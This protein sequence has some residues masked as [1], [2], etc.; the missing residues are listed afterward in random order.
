MLIQHNFITKEVYRPVP[1][2]SLLLLESMKIV[3]TIGYAP[4]VT[5]MKRNYIPEY[6]RKVMHCEVQF[7]KC[8]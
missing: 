6:S 7:I 2:I 8:L 3:G 5:S 4:N 1:E